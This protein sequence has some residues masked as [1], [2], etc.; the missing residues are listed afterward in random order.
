MTSSTDTQT[1]DTITMADTSGLRH[2]RSLIMVRHGRT[3][4]NAQGR[5]QGQID[6]PLDDVGRWQVKHTAEA[7]IDLYC[8]G[9]MKAAH[10]LVLCSDLGRAQE[11]AHAFADA[12]GVDVH[13]DSRLRE[14]NFGEWEGK[15][16]DE[17]RR[18]YPRDF[19]SWREFTGGELRHGAEPKS[20]VG[21]RGTE[22]INEWSRRA[23]DDTNLFVF[24][25]GAWISETLQTML[26]LD[27]MGDFSALVSMRN[28]HWTRL[29]PLDMPV[30][31]A[32][33]RLV[34]Y[35]HGPAAADD[36]H[37]EHPNHEQ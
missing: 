37:W 33:W 35:N 4:Y 34:D 20:H 2:V 10:Q 8:T 12:I 36:A 27:P 26:G 24:S 30:G 17:L 18:D 15:T 28:A 14:R 7:L 1:V 21:E 23:T 19:R 3:S 6:I 29:V 25:H 22:A 9:R 13:P 11:T 5:L 32:R 31:L 16:G